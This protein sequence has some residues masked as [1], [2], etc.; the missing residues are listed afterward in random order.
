MVIITRADIESALGPLAYIIPHTSLNEIQSACFHPLLYTD[1]NMVIAAPT[2]SGKTLLMELALLRL[3]AAVRPGQFKAVYISPIK[4]LAQEK[5]TCWEKKFSRMNLSVLL[6]TGDTDMFDTNPQKVAQAD[7]LVTTPERWDSITRSWKE[8]AALALVTS[9]ALVLIDEVHTVDDERGAVLEALVS[10]MKTIHKVRKA[11]TAAGLPSPLMRF[12]AVS[13]TMPNADDVA[14]WLDVPPEGLC[15]FTEA[16]RPMPLHLKV[17]SYPSNSNN[18]F[19]YDRL[20]CF[21]LCGLIH[22]YSDGKPSLIFCPSRK[23]TETSALAVARDGPH[24]A[25]SPLPPRLA[26][27][28]E[29]CDNNA[30]RQCLSRGV[31]FHHA[32]LSLPDR[33]TVEDLFTQQVL[34]VVC[35]TST[36]AIG[37]N[38][39]AR[40]V[41]VKGT[42][43]FKGGAREDLPLS[44]V[45]QMV[46]RAGRAGFDTHG[47]GIILTTEDKAYHYGALCRGN[48]AAQTAIESRLHK[49]L[50]EHVNADIALLTIDSAETAHEWIRTTFFY[51]R[52][53]KNPTHYGVKA[54]TEI[55]T[56]IDNLIEN[57]LTVL[58]NAEC[59]QGQSAG[60]GMGGL[61]LPTKIGKILAKY[62]T[63]VTTLRVMHEELQPHSDVKALLCC[64]SKAEEMR[65]FRIRQGDKG[66]LNPQNKNLR[67]PL[68]GGKKNHEI[69]ED[70]HKIYSL[71]QINLDPETPVE[72]WSLKNELTRIWGC[73]PRLVK[74]FE[75][76][77]VE[78]G[79]FHAAKNAWLLLRCV[80]QKMWQDSPY[81]TRQLEG[82][83]DTLSRSFS[84][85][86]ITTLQDLVSK[87]PHVLESI[88]GRHPPFGADLQLKVNSIPIFSVELTQQREDAGLT[89]DTCTIQIVLTRAPV[90]CSLRPTWY[91]L[92]VGNSNSALLLHRRFKAHA[93]EAAHMK[94]DFKATR[95][96][97]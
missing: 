65:E 49:R 7:I 32:A 27:A 90:H 35:A 72:E 34:K 58:R 8:G 37:V 20:L 97:G 39:P 67:F 46:G 86:G 59:V 3:F 13:G 4:A 47:V 29:K 78:K 94:W 26:A 36:L 70:W 11:K 79:Y 71:I 10:R 57:Q 92:L 53:Q 18:A 30:L 63:Y 17:L 33:R 77:C 15:V 54:G 66:H 76:F 28:A 73:L 12:I 45:Q 93:S 52:V 89:S 60:G 69:K 56:F 25:P 1:T 85:A 84:R 51:V 40:L 62:Y 75:E 74:L 55:K 91:T 50:P 96:G 6:E 83:G 41:I 24:F 16:Q 64:L 48:G 5:A 19:G 95:G 23:E 87:D 88:T 82:V 43:G 81:L 80:K 42:A 38:L 61:I 44:E 31:G 21:K 22:Q 68:V 2:G 14:T 9:V